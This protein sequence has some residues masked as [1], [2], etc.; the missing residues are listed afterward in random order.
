[1]QQHIRNPNKYTTAGQ[2]TQ[3]KC[4]TKQEETALKECEI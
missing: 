4:K 3:H 2:K 1:M